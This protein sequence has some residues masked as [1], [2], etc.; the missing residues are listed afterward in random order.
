M[1]ELEPDKLAYRV[2]ELPRVTGLGR[3]KIYELI[4]RGVIPSVELGGV[5][6]VPVDGLRRAIQ[7]APSAAKTR[8]MGSEMEA[9]GV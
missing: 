7:S 4:A 8:A 6:L 3:S 5:I 9:V 1:L 2:A